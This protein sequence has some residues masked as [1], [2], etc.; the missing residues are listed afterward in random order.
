MVSSI[1][2]LKYKDIIVAPPPTRVEAGYG[3]GSLTTRTA[4]HDTPPSFISINAG[5][6]VRDKIRGSSKRR[7]TENHRQHDGWC[8]AAAL[9]V[10]AWMVWVDRKPRLPNRWAHD[11]LT[12]CD[13]R[14]HSRIAS[15]G[16]LHSAAPRISR[17]AAE[18]QERDLVK[19]SHTRSGG[20]RATRVDGLCR[21]REGAHST[22]LQ[23][24]R[25]H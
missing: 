13:R 22:R 7:T 16:R 25:H 17:A 11:L 23:P 1:V 10:Q 15:A 18:G 8:W 19:G 21:P 24:L 20:L 14:A 9:S 3:G 6:S 12:T 2:L 5:L 4:A